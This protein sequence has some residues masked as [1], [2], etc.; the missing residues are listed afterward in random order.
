MS[1]AFRR[2]TIWFLLRVTEQWNSS[3]LRMQTEANKVI[4]LLYS[5]V[6]KK[7]SATTSP[8]SHL[9]QGLFSSLSLNVNHSLCF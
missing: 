4:T 7:S 2:K 3:H 5:S 8:V 9:T 6:A 1:V